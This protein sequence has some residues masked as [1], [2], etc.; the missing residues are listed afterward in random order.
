MQ[1]EKWDAIL[2]GSTLPALDRPR[3]Q[4][5]THWAKGLAYAAKGEA[6][7]A[8]SAL[9]AMDETLDVYQEKVKQPVPAELRVARQELTAHILAAKGKLPQAIE[10]LKKT[11]L[12]ERALVYSE[13]PFYPRPVNDALGR[14]ALK[15]GN[16]E[17]AEKAYR[18]ALEQYPD[19]A[20]AKAGLKQ[21]EKKGAASGAVD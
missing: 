11:V 21:I 19:S 4:A 8:Q 3:E 13:P 12:R 7:E 2:D 6:A 17:V 14:L 10:K 15:A 1:H 20:I 18:E 9:D 5:W 16:M